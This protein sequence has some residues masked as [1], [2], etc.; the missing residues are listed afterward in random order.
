VAATVPEAP[1]RLSPAVVRRIQ[2]RPVPPDGA[3]VASEQ[4]LAD[5]FTEAKVLPGAVRFAD[6]ADRRWNA[7]VTGDRQ[8]VHC[9]VI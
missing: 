7:D 5:A 4:P 9:G 3:V 2:R 8:R 1:P 6:S